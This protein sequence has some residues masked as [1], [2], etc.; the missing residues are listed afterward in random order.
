MRASARL[1]SISK[2]EN[3]SINL[4]MIKDSQFVQK[5]REAVSELKTQFEEGM[6]Q[7]LEA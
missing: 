7:A 4:E 5:T 6:K 3:V 1:T 2:P